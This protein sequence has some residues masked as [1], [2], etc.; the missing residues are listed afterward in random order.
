MVGGAGGPALVLGIEA[1]Q[2]GTERQ[3]AISKRNAPECV[4]VR[5]VLAG[6]ALTTASDI[7]GIAHFPAGAGLK[8]FMCKHIY[9]LS[10]A[11]PL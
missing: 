5:A 9:F 7:L 10:G 3:P 11:V 4:A 1:A 8:L 6:A 2:V